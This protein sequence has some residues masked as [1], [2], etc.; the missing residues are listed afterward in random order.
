MQPSGRDEAGAFALFVGADT[1]VETQA[2]I[3][4]SISGVA[5]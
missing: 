5:P 1:K 2:K 4:E 3:V